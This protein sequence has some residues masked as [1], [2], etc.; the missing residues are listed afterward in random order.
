MMMALLGLR[1]VEGKRLEKLA[2]EEVG[3]CWPRNGSLRAE[4]LS[5]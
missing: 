2:P 3:D 4:E 1:A 5:P